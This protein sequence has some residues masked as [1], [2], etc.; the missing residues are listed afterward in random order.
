MTWELMSIYLSYMQV[1]IEIILIIY[2]NIIHLFIRRER[3]KIVWIAENKNSKEGDIAIIFLTCI[4]SQTHIFRTFTIYLQYIFRT[5]FRRF[6]SSALGFERKCKKCLG[7]V[8][9]CNWIFERRLTSH[10]RRISHSCISQIMRR[11]LG[12]SFR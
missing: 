9:S 2:T 7:T 3:L 4:H 6:L 12:K 8:T 1:Y 10:L 11:V 5:F